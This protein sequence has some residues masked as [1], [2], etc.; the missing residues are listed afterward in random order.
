M[1]PDSITPLPNTLVHPQQQLY[2]S[3]SIV[4]CRSQDSI[5]RADSDFGIGRFESDAFQFLNWYF[6]KRICDA[7]MHFNSYIFFSFFFSQ[8]HIYILKEVEVAFKS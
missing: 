4:I 3:I 2:L 5:L 8:L 1:P 7:E 6:E